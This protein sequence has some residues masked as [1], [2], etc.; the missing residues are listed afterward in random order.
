[1]VA[2]MSV[3]TLDTIALCGFD[4]RFNSFYQDEMHPFIDGLVRTLR[5]AL[6]RVQRLPC[7]TSSCL[8]NTAN[9]SRTLP[10]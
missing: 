3:L 6:E 1:M 7:N 2:D 8:A 4:Y 9:M 5:E 10:T